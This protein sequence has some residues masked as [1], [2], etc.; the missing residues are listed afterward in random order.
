M[1]IL[2]PLRPFFGSLF[3][4][5]TLVFL[6]I[7][8]AIDIFDML[9]TTETIFIVLDIILLLLAILYILAPAISNTLKKAKIVYIIGISGRILIDFV[10]LA[11]IFSIG[12]MP[13]DI[14]NYGL[15]LDFII[16]ILTVAAIFPAL[17]NWSPP[18][19]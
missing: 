13:S 18:L 5:F 16:L 10:F 9:S 6:I 14:F 2:N 3:R 7:V 8:I 11:T 4:V 1:G 12:E 15:I 17:N 19:P